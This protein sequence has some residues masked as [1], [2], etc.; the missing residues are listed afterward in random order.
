MK[1]DDAV[2]GAGILG[3]AHAYHLAR[4]GRRVVVF[5]RSPEACGASVRNFGM[6]WPI[7]Q[8]AGKRHEIAL[9]SRAIWLEVL[10]AAQL[11]HDPVGSLHVAYHEDEAAVLREF[12][13]SGPAQGYSV[14]LLSPS[15]ALTK[16]P[17]LRS[18]G[19]RCALWS[20]IEV[21][22]DPRQ[23]IGRLPA[24]LHGEWGVDF[25]FDHLVTG[26][27]NGQ[28]R[29]QGRT[30]AADRL[31]VS[32]GDDLQTLYPDELA[33]LG[34]VRCKLQ[35]MRTQAY[36]NSFRLGV[37]LA[38]GLTLGHYPAFQQCSTLP[39]LR[40]RFRRELP[41]YGEF[42]IHVLVSQQGTGEVTLGDSHEYGAD[43]SNFSK[44]EIDQLVLDYLHGFLELP[45]M[46]IASRW[47]GYY[48][49]HPAEP[50]T[51]TRPAPKV[52]CTTGVGGNGMT[53]SFGLVE[54][55]VRET[56]D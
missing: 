18:E 14:E 36:G 29:A 32:A 9:R 5:E 33:R 1:Y 19:L 10:R 8:P 28:V 35:M 55:I 27:E 25:H 22:V 41:R 15:Q 2:V 38:A 40:E 31:W 20:P 52:I 30:F 42:G 39:A 4:R 50:W 6:I 46:R 23:V 56:L 51:V 26:F 12:V 49:K 43:I 37:M 24:Y 34:L 21:C 13:A 3:L 45:E 53:L 48:I 54:Q 17:A 16:C 11:W 47:Q 7:G 44:E